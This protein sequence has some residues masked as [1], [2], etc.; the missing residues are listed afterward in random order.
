LLQDE[1]WKHL[2]LLSDDAGQ[3]AVP[4]LRP[5]LCGV[6]AERTM[7]KRNPGRPLQQAA[8]ERVRGEIWRLDKDLKADGLQ[9]DDPQGE[10]LAARFDPVLRQKTG[11]V[12]LDLAWRRLHRNRE[13]WLLVLERP[14]VPLH[15]KGRERDIREQVIRQKIR[16]GTRSELGRQCRDP[17]LR[18]KKTCRKLGLS[19]GHYRLDRIQGD[20]AIPPLPV[21]IRQRA[22]SLAE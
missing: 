19:F 5:G 6:H 15:T 12:S 22:N 14:E 3:F 13:E 11:Y 9:P 21:R 4:L 17:V 2:A 10:D 20:H 7:H 1:H 18:L 8:V 16:G